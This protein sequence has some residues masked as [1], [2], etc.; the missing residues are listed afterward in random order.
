VKPPPRDNRL[1]DAIEA[2]PV[3]PF[4]GTVWRVVKEGRDPCLGS[5]AG[6][7]WD[8]GQFSV[9]YT[10]CTRDGAIAEM[11]FHLKRGQP[12][13][14]S[15]LRYTLHEIRVKLSGV[16]DLSDLELLANFGLDITKYGQLSYSDRKAEYPTTQQIADAAH[17]LGSSEQGDASGILVPSARS[18][19]ANLVIFCDHAAPGSYEDMKNHG[20]IRWPK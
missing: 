7:R 16:F 3:K 18:S 8:N 6:N 10:S 11:Y 4:E 20:I 19:C 14:P 2:I 5:A 17:F 13:F 12:V 1:F 9:L 15:K